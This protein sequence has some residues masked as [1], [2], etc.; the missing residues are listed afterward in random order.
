MAPFLG[1]LHHGR[2]FRK[3]CEACRLCEV[4]QSLGLGGELGFSGEVVSCRRSSHKDAAI[5]LD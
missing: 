4:C 5:F 3:F 1:L 2:E